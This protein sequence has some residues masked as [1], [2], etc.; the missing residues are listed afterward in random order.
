MGAQ[1]APRPAPAFK[2]FPGPQ[3]DHG[4]EAG[5]V[6]VG[7]R[8]VDVTVVKRGAGEASHLDQRMRGVT[9]LVRMMIPLG[10][11]GQLSV[12]SLCGGELRFLCR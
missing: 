1:D 3:Q 11:G 5:A 6:A 7:V 12:S 8:A 9:P 4:G 2:E 10:V